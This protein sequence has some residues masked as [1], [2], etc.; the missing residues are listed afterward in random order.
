MAITVIVSIPESD[1]QNMARM[2]LEERVCA[3]VNI[4][5]GVQSLYWWKGQITE[6][7]EAILIMKT[8]D[9]LYPKLKTMVKNNHPYEVPEIISYKIDQVN[10]E[11]LDWLNKEASA[12]PAT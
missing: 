1:A 11:Y 12:N 9:S 5:K 4:V 6:A 7:N 8:K 2:L 10:P 3:C